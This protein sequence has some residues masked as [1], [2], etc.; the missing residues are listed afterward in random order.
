M[1]TTRRFPKNKNTGPLS[2]QKKEKSSGGGSNN[3]PPTGYTLI[4]HSS[5]GTPIYQGPDGKRIATTDFGKGRDYLPS[6]RGAFTQYAGNQP[7]SGGI[8]KGTYNKSV[9][10]GKDTA[11][12]S[13]NPMSPTMGNAFEGIGDAGTQNIIT[14]DGIK[15]KLI[16]EGNDLLAMPWEDQGY[17]AITEDGQQIK[18]A[19]NNKGEWVQMAEPFGEIPLGLPGQAPIAGMRPLKGANTAAMDFALLEEAKKA[20]K[21]ANWINDIKETNRIIQRLHKNAPNQIGKVGAN[22]KLIKKGQRYAKRVVKAMKQPKTV[23]PL[24]AAAIV[25]AIGFS[26]YSYPWAAHLD[27]DNIIPIY[28]MQ[29]RDLREMGADDLADELAAGRMEFIN[30]SQSNWEAQIPGW[31]ILWR[32]KEEIKAIMAGEA[33]KKQARE[34]IENGIIESPSNVDWDEIRRKEEEAQKRITDYR[35]EEEKK[36]LKFE[37]EAYDRDM[38]EDA[39]FWRNEREEQRK[40]EKEQLKWQRDF[41]KQYRKEIMEMERKQAMELNKLYEN[42]K[43]SQ[44]NFGLLG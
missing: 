16:R 10:I 11:P 42:K 31:N 33:A 29:E 1:P 15:A 23:G 25:G 41:W 26:A 24:I 22:T 12:S 32:K 3:S 8:Q 17:I 18:V 5:I 13:L 20:N 6:G 38:K 37:E 4:G 39:E 19:K 30:K 35:I 44:L 14:K 27:I 43:P 21:A 34:D 40:K 2:K 9:T 28:T 36:L 7:T